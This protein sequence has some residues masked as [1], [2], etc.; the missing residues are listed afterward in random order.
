MLNADL[1]A[2]FTPINVHYAPNLSAAKHLLG[3]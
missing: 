3:V 1:Q 2:E